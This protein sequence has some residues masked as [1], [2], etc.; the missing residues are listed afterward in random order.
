MQAWDL[1]IFPQPLYPDSLLSLK[2]KSRG[3]GLSKIVLKLVHQGDITIGDPIKSQGLAGVVQVD[4]HPA[5]HTH[6]E[7]HLHITLPCSILQ[8][9]PGEVVP[10][11]S[12]V[13]F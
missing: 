12:G 10:Q 2:A 13:A 3:I 9:A 6:F 11:S 4:P 5:K 8:D 7:G 1:S